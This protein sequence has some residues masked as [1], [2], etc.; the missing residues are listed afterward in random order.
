MQ[1]TLDERKKMLADEFLLE[2]AAKPRKWWQGSPDDSYKSTWDIY[3]EHNYRRVFADEIA[4]RNNKE[5]SILKLTF[6]SLFGLI[7]FIVSISNGNLVFQVI[8]FM[9]LAGF[10]FLGVQELLDRSSKLLINQE[11]LWAAKWGFA[12]PWTDIVFSCIRTNSSGESLSHLLRIHFY[13]PFE[14]DFKMVE[15]NVDG[16][17]KEPDTIACFVQQFRGDFGKHNNEQ[18]ASRPEAITE[19]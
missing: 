4:I 9:V 15:C 6:T 19:P 11:G 14:D 2:Y 1:R 12:I 3:K 8:A 18:T 5:D 13:D 10:V 16:L 17:E 7:F